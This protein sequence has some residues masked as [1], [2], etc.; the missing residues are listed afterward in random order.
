MNTYPISCYHSIC[1]TNELE[2]IF[3]MTSYVNIHVFLVAMRYAFLFKYRKLVNNI[4]GR[5]E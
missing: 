3:M 5:H 1:V 2:I 4:V